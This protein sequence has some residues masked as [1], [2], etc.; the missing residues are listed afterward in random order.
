VGLDFLIP[1]KK[2]ALYLSIVKSPNSDRRYVCFG[3]YFSNPDKDCV[4]VWA[5]EISPSAQWFLAHKFE[6]GM[7]NHVHNIIDSPFVDRVYVLTGDFGSAAAIWTCTKE[8]KSFRVLLS[9]AQRVRACWATFRQT[10]IIFASDTQL[11]LNNVYFSHDGSIRKID[12]IEGPSI[13]FAEAKGCVYFSTS[14]EPGAPSGNFL[15]DLFCRKPGV[16][17]RSNEAYIYSLDIANTIA[18]VLKAEKDFIPMRLG[19][20]GSFMFPSGV[21]GSE[22]VVAYGVAL[23]G[24][25]D[26]ALL[27]S[28]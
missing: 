27:L 24:F 3:E 2:T 5:R 26:C 8:F 14:V 16:G 7:I 22:Q 20:F 21:S 6:R 15:R 23:K 4:N 28:R 19:Q 9:G 12:V 10:D 13:Y 25:D 11:E 1:E 18:P 17:V